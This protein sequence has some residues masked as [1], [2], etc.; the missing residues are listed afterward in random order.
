MRT[1][2]YNFSDKKMKMLFQWKILILFDI[3]ETQLFF[4]SYK[5]KAHRENVYSKT[6]YFKTLHCI[7]NLRMF[8]EILNKNIWKLVNF[9]FEKI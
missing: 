5:W 8:P 9:F 1:F 2:Y 6:I 3:L 4:P 7:K